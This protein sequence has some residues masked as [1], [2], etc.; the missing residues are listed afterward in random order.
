[1]AALFTSGRIIDII[2]AL[3]VVE[4]AALIF[5]KRFVGSGPRRKLVLAN[6]LAG[7]SLLLAVR[8]ALV[9]AEW[10]WIAACLSLALIAHVADMA[11]RWRER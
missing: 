10:P 3:V 2:L 7:A 11:G 6:I 5:W 8:L 1:M 4:F 9:A